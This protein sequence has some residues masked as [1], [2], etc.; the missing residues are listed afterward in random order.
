MLGGGYSITWNTVG[1]KPPILAGTDTLTPSSYESIYTLQ[2]G[3]SFNREILFVELRQSPVS[4]TDNFTPIGVPVVTSTTV[5]SWNGINKVERVSISPAPQ[6]GSY[7]I[8]IGTHSASINAFASAIDIRSALAGAG[9]TSV[10][11]VSQTGSLQF[12][13]VLSSDDVLTVN[14]SGLVQSS[15]YAGTLSFATSE[16]IAF[17]GNSTSASAILEI[18]VEAS[19]VNTTVCQVPCTLANGVI[20]SGA[21][22]PITVGTIL[23]ESVANARFIRKDLVDAPSVATQDIL[24]QNL[25]VSIDGSNTVAAINNASSPSAGNPFATISQVGDSFNQSLNTTDSVSFQSV[26]SVD[27]FGVGGA[28]VL[29]KDS[30]QLNDD[31][32]TTSLDTV[33]GLNLGLGGVTFPDDTTQ[34]TAF[35]PS[36]YLTSTQIQNTYQTIS[37]MSS[38]LTT[39]SAASTYQTIS[40]MSSY[41][42]TSAASSTYAPLANFDQSLLTSDDVVF[43][44]VGTGV[45]GITIGQT[46]IT[47][48][49]G[50]T[51]DTAAGGS[52]NNFYDYTTQPW[53]IISG[54]GSQ[55]SGAFYKGMNNNA[56]HNSSL[57][58]PLHNQYTSLSS[59]PNA[60]FFQT[61]WEFVFS[62]ISSTTV[63]SDSNLVQEM[64]FTYN[65]GGSDVLALGVR[66]IGF[67]GSSNDEIHFVY[68]DDSGSQT[69]INTGATFWS[70]VASRFKITCDGAGVIKLFNESDNPTTNLQVVWNEI[71][72]VTTTYG[73]SPSFFRPKS[74]MIKSSTT[75]GGGSHVYSLWMGNSLLK[76]EEGY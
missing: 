51:Q 14:G 37:G 27:G 73:S 34:T 68:L 31:I 49:D 28:D 59:T 12:D 4:L 32:N 71:A 35:I 61:P 9:A 23:T 25:G 67:G 20:S 7:N 22:S 26:N 69:V 50:S 19:G 30:L 21:V 70:G 47:F 64:G 8:K 58:L 15:G 42:T 55:T 66:M 11:S 29:F 33:N 38:Y 56:S 40:G 10:V 41:L 1:T 46:A 45:F 13:I 2:V 53:E 57:A 54:A 72:S 74:L 24:W 39:S 18:I 3:D 63:S 16:I 43:N 48:P 5:Q 6:N 17:L 36:N 75:T 60:S 65:S 76:Y 62:W 52:L 44:S